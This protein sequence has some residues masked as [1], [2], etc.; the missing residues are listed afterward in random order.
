MTISAVTSLPAIDIELDGESLSANA[1]AALEEVRVQR[2]LS[3]PSVCELTFFVT[4]NS[5][6]DLEDLRAGRALRLM[7]PAESASLFEGEITALE[8]GY[9]AAHGRT[10]RVRCYDKLHRLRKRQPVRTHVQVTPADLARE[11]VADLGLSVDASSEGPLVQSMIQHRQSDLELLVELAQRFG[12]YLTL[13]EGVLHLIGLDGTGDTVELEWGTTLLEAR[14]E[15]NA[16]PACRAVLAKGWDA[17]RVEAHESRAD[18]PSIGRE[19]DAEAPPD[20]FDSNGKRTLTDEVLVDD[21]QASAV[22]Q[23]ELNL[24]RAREVTFSG[25]A[26][27][28]ADL[29]PGTTV[30]VS[31][32]QSDL[33]GRYV[34]T[35]VTHLVNRRSGFVTEVS[36]IPP[37]FEKRTANA[38]V[39]WGTV[40][41]VEDPEKLGRVRVKLPTLGE[42]ETEWMGV[43]AIGAGGGKGLVFLPDVGDEVV[44][45]FVGGEMRQGFVL[46]GL[47][48]TAN[49][50]DY[51]VEGSSVRRFTLGTPG[52]QRLKLDDTAESIR[53]ENKGGTFVEFSPKKF[54]LHSEVDLEIEAPGRA[55]VIKGNTIDFRQA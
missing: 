12:L 9:E 45:M 33:E 11:L 51:G 47:W 19:V 1:A 17:S 43:M 21:R 23:A 38:S 5:I 18:S 26:E 41:N 39:I 50:G 7:L 42:V 3:Q 8:Y 55:V 49:P 2:R 44:V 28:N 25:V 37:K 35:S 16:E 52:G 46:G 10:L 20:L 30:D 40:T 13:R 4:R 54:R 53:L 29:L 22:A 15:V 27:G 32:V 48:G 24:R 34:L 14:F 6:T 36:T 31:G